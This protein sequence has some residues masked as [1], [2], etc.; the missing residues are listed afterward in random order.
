MLNTEVAATTQ[1]LIRRPVHEVFNA[2]ID[3]AVTTKIWFTR[4]SGRVEAGKHL[5][6]DWEMHGA[7]AQVDVIEVEVDKRI[8]IQWPYGPNATPTIVEWNFTS[9]PDDATFVT[10]VNSGFRGT[11]DEIAQQAVGATGGFSYVL[12]GA[13]ALLEHGVI[14]NL[15]ADHSPPEDNPS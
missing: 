4:S 6:W 2:F 7:I 5:Q 10:I 9:A 14:L 12:A 8:V 11:D 3:P 1:M 15:I 13:K